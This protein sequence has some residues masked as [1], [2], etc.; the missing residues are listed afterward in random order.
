ME[1]EANSQMLSDIIIYKIFFSVLETP[2]VQLVLTLE[3]PAGYWN[4]IKIMKS[5][6]NLCIDYVFACLHVQGW[7][8]GMLCAIVQMR[9]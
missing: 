7:G 6:R 1:T 4:E 5:T 3:A 9:I 8:G 2:L